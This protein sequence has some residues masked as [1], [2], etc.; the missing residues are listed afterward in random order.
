MITK[1][2]LKDLLEFLGF[3]ES[4]GVYSKSFKEIDATLKV[5]FIKE[6]LIYPEDKGLTV[7]ERQTCNF[8]SNENF[9]VLECVHRLLEK[10]YKPEHI[11]LEPKWKVGHGASGGRADILIKDNT[12]KSLLII[13]CKTAGKEHDKAWEDTHGNGG[14]LFS[15]VQQARSTKFIC[16]YSSDFVDGR[17]VFTH[18]IIIMQDNESLLEEKQGLQPLSYKD[19]QQVE[20]L[21][22]AWA[23]T[24]GKDYATKGI[25]EDDIPAYQIGKNKFSLNDLQT[26]SSKDIQGKYHEFATILRQHNVSGHENAFDKLVN[27][28]LCKI[29]DENR[30]PDELKFYWKGIAY[31]SNF[32][33]QDR[34]QSLYKAGM[35]EFLGENVTYIDNATIDEAFLFFKNDPDATRDII[36]GYF[37]E[38]K[39]F[40][41]ND[42]AFIDVHN[43]NLFRQNAAVLLKIVRMFQDIHLKTNE[44]NQFLGDMFEGFLDQGIKQSEGQFFT[45]MPIVKFILS[46]LPLEKIIIEHEQPPQVIDYA[47]GAGHFLNE[48][49]MQI[50]P[51]VKQHKTLPLTDYHAATVG[52]EKE[53]RLS[54]VAKVSAFMYGQDAIQIIYSDALAD[55][56]KV[57]DSSYS[58]LIANPPYSVKGFLETLTLSDRNRFELM[59]SIEDRSYASNNSIETFFIERAKQLLKSDGM[60]GIIM[61]L[62]V[63]SKGS[64]KTTAKKTNVYVAARE[65][66]LKYFDIIAIAEFGSGTFGKTGTKT[67]TLFLRRRK[68]TPPAAD[69]YH[70]RIESWFNGDDS[71]NGIFADEHF[72]RSYCSHLDY[73]LDDYKTLLRGKTNGNLLNTDMFTEYRKDFDNLSET[74]NRK[75]QKSF[76]ALN[77]ADQ[78]S[79]LERKFLAYI[80]TIEKDKLYYF[81][82]ANLNPAK[83]VIV[84]SPSGNAE[85]KKFLGYEWSSAKGNEGIKYLGGQ[86]VK[87]EKDEEGEEEALEQD[88]K[89]VLENLLKLNNI[90]TPLYDPHDLLNSDK[91]NSLIRANFNGEVVTVPEALQ[92]FVTTAGLVDMLDFSRKEFNKA[93][94][95]TPKKSIAIESKWELVKLGDLMSF[96]YGKNLPEESRVEGEY[97]V[98]GSNGIISYH[99]KFIVQ[100]PCI[101]IGRKGSAGKVNWIDKDCNPIDT[102]FYVKEITHKTNYQYLYLILGTIGLDKLSGGTGVPG[103]NRDDAYSQNIPLPP[104]DVQQQIVNECEAV[105]KEVKQAR[106]AIEQ[107]KGELEKEISK[108]YTS[109]FPRQKLS[110][111]VEIISGGT[112]STSKPEYWNGDIPWLSVADFNN[113]QRYVATTEKTITEA[114]LKNSSTKYLQKDDLIISAR[115][116]VGALAQ[117]AVPMT[118][119]QS[120][121][122]LRGKLAIDNGFLYYILGREVQQFKDNAYGSKFDSITIRTFDSIQIPL[123]DMNTQKM[124]VSQIEKTEPTITQAKQVI[125]NSAERKRAILKEYL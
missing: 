59:G 79:E 38:L 84:R 82:L 70:N 87:I 45:P 25:F 111:I 76:K 88:D 19:A 102:T 97:P 96:E 31:D 78:Q 116:T 6:E 64:S 49:A 22:K 18:Q 44:Q 11:E 30:N 46:S 122:G 66:L 40:T 74:K 3:E 123:P 73:K 95:L 110:N 61:P 89:R 112:P 67:V 7:N 39:F 100:A 29:V 85:M 119:N 51:V 63:C 109:H 33:L 56:P 12:E 41:N 43:E 13:E 55:N 118:F 94:S 36:K 50:A 14:Q 71:K 35:E 42:F 16:L 72:I 125:E 48:Y 5:D 107:T 121:Y 28:F 68:Q 120:C 17:A 62:S 124:M 113:E 99:H 60:A 21:F 104:L 26:I 75:K 105:D 1:N 10:G 32:D 92:E 90:Q 47:C 52:I 58:L 80:Q 86:S 103:L 54:K 69:H 108:I 93:I 4:K 23:E 65:I 37:R 98:V 20:N 34:L 57:K 27:L 9:V 114:G 15:Y 117:M 8:S 2:N 115:G 106:Q 101:V 83:T 77:K 81:V 53:Y 24:Y 91:I